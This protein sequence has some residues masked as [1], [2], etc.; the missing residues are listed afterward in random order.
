MTAD[1]HRLIQDL[2][3]FVAEREWRPFHT[4]RIL[5]VGLS[6]EA[7]GLLER[8]QSLFGTE[9]NASDADNRARIEEE[10]G[11]GLSQR[12][13]KRIS[14]LPVNRHRNLTRYRGAPASKSDHA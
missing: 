14:W 11:A 12:Y 5:A 2:R 9:S 7:S 6:I 3:A 10:I 1:L 13:L 4:A 8:F